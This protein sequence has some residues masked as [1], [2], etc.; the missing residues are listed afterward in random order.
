MNWLD[1]KPGASTLICSQAHF[2]L[3]LHLRHPLLTQL[4][5]ACGKLGDE[6]GSSRADKTFKGMKVVVDDKMES[7]TSKMNQLVSVLPLAS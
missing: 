3:S 4:F 5:Q 7:S 6:G 2:F 1:G